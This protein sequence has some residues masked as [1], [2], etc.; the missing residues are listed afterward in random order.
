[1]HFAAKMAAKG[2]WREARFR[3]EQAA[4]LD[5]GDPYLWNNLA[6]AAEALGEYT[7]ARQ[8]YERA[9]QL[10]PQDPDI[11]DNAR[12]NAYLL[13]SLES[14]TEEPSPAP[15]GEA[16]RR[17]RGKRGK[18]L[19]VTVSLPV[20]ARLD[21][22]GYTSLLVAAFQ[23]PEAERVDLS[24]ELA[25]YL[26]SQFRRHTSLEVLEVNPPPAIPEQRVEDLL[27]NLEFWRH[28]GATHGAD[29]IVSGRARFARRDASGFQDV[30]LISPATGQKVRQTRFVEQEEFSL[31]IELWYLDG[32]NGALL[33]RDRVQRTGVFGGTG[34][35]A[36]TALYELSDRMA[37]DLLGSVTLQHH[38]DLRVIFR[39]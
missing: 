12:R 6:V 15:A 1:M 37:G 13:E 34:N 36:L 28:L 38:Q 29:I 35:D 4:D 24:R 22:T 20:P 2:Q 16:P 39:G 3:W 14:R 19:P 26:R 5:P 33:L 8:H 27:A 23:V 30:D 17:P 7:T 10:A 21:L 31:E 11:G 18:R 25:R 9:L 32:R